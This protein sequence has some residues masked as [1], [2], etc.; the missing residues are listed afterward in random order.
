MKLIETRASLTRPDDTEQYSSGDLIANSVDSSEVIPLSF[1]IP[2]GRG[3][4]LWRVELHRSS[5][6]TAEAVFRLHIYKN[7]PTSAAG[8]NEAFLTNVSSY[9]GYI[10]IDGTEGSFTDGSKASGVFVNNS[11]FAPMLMLTNPD[12]KIYGLLEARGGYTP[13]ENEVFTVFLLGE[14]YV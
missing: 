7:P 5:T 11:V 10:D 12:Q 9:Q 3:L 1:F 14:S 2:Y 6:N 13:E 8:D 4:R